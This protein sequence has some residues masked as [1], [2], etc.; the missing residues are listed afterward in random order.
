MTPGNGIPAIMPGIIKLSIPATNTISP[1]WLPPSASINLARAEEMRRERQRIARLFRTRL[2][3]LEQI[4]L[5]PDPPDR[6]HA[7]HLFPIRLRLDKLSIDR[8][9]FITELRERGV[10]CSV[11]WRPLH[12]HPYYRAALCLAAGT[13]AGGVGPVAEARHAPPV[14]RHAGRR[15]RAS[16]RSG[17]PV[18]RPVREVNDTMV[19]RHVGAEGKQFGLHG[20]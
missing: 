11:H 12:L 17:P 9:R 4:D 1:T 19:H 14:S 10:G 5:P 6:L 20:I 7:W 2:A 3:D 16:G 15:V 8:N 18:V 13:P